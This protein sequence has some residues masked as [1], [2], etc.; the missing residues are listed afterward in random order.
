MKE[1]I[2]IILIFVISC[3]SLAAQTFNWFSQADSRWKQEQLGYSRYNTIGRSGCVLSCLTML[4]NAEASTPA[5]TPDL[6]N[7]WLQR[8]N[9]FSGA[10]MRW[11]VLSDF[12]GGIEGIQYEG[13]NNHRNDWSYLSDQLTKGNKVLVKVGYGRGHW[14]LV[15]AQHGPYNNPGSY[16]VN[17]PGTSQYRDKTLAAWGGFKA[18]R[19]Y[20]GNWIDATTVK[21]ESNLTVTPVSKNESFLYNLIHL[22]HPADVYVSVKNDLNVPVTGY[23]L[24]AMFDKN[25]NFLKVIDSEYSTIAKKD[26]KDFLYSIDNMQELREN[27]NELRL[28]FSKSYRDGNDPESSIALSPDEMENT[29]SYKFVDNPDNNEEQ[30][31]MN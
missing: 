24:L 7:S 18:A 4:V 19:S 10:D 21:M 22:D 12:D 8:N 20:S 27:N 25:G 6:L 3:S 15:I 17:D 26:S 13:Q 11:E 30:G 23:F 9:G 31:D 2:L 16:T 1:K 14:V 29:I 28:I 5:V